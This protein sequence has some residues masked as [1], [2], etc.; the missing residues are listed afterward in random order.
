MK[1]STITDRVGVKLKWMELSQ[2][3]APFHFKQAPPFTFLHVTEGGVERRRRKAKLQDAVR[4][5]L[6]VVELISFMM[7]PAFPGRLPL[8][9]QF[10]HCCFL[11]SSKYTILSCDFP[12]PTAAKMDRKADAAIDEFDSEHPKFEVDASVPARYHGTAADAR[13]MAV[14]GKKQVLRVCGLHE[15]FSGGRKKC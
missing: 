3:Q 15:D 14:L 4:A 7:S 10:L 5:A 12:D 6:A 2:D 9:F 8:C 11:S 1:S 13:D